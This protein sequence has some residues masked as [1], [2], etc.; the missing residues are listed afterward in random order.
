MS[1]FWGFEGLQSWVPVCYSAIK[2][3][4]FEHTG[5]EDIDV[6]GLE[7]TIAEVQT[8]THILV[9]LSLILISSHQYGYTRLYQ[10]GS[11]IALGDAA[12][13]R[14]PVTISTETST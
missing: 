7:L 2:I 4:I 11:P 10:D 6:P 8:G 13:S 14:T 12:G 1:G 3:D 9:Q 5:K